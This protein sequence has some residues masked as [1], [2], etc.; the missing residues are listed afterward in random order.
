MNIFI[1]IT[2]EM[3]LFLIYLMLF[4]YIFDINDKFTN[5]INFTDVF[6]L[7]NVVTRKFLIRY[8]A[9]VRFPFNDVV[10]EALEAKIMLIRFLLN[11][12]SQ[13]I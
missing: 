13:I 2:V 5:K 3:I 4:R 9:Q 8:V 7:Y 11:Y 6:L 1:P 12:N 10:L